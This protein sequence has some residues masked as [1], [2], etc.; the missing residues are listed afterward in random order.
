M[1]GTRQMPEHAKLLSY[2]T[3]RKLLFHPFLTDDD[4]R[5]LQ[6]FVFIGWFYAILIK[7]VGAHKHPEIM[8]STNPSKLFKAIIKPLFQCAWQLMI[9]FIHITMWDFYSR[10]LFIRTS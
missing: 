3:D 5:A 1:S 4:A 8:A 2:A 7:G 6:S 10:S 9:Y